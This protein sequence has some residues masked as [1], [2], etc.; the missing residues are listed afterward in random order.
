[1]KKVL[2]SL[3]SSLFVCM[4]AYSQNTF[5][6]YSCDFEDANE[7]S[8]WTLNPTANATLQGQ[9]SNKWYIGAAGDFSPTGSN[10]LFVSSD[11]GQEAVYD[12]NQTMFV[13][14][15]RE[16]PTTLPAGNY[17]LRFFW[18]GAG[19]YVSGEGV[20]VC[21]VPVSQATNSA[22]SAGGLPQWV[23]DY[24]CDS[25]NSAGTWTVANLP[26][27]HDGT[28][29][30]LVFVWYSTRGAAAPPSGCIDGLELSPDISC[31]CP[32]NVSHEMKGD[33]VVLHWYGEITN[34]TVQCYDP[35]SDTWQVGTPLLD[36]TC[37]L[38]NV[39]EG[40]QTFFIRGYCD[41]GASDIVAYTAFVFHRGKRC[42]DYMDL[43]DNN[44]Y[45]G[46]YENPFQQRQ[47]VDYGY[48][49]M[50]SR[51]TLHYMPNQYD[52]NTNYQLL[53]C[54]EGYLTSVRLGY[55]EKG[56]GNHLGHGIEY[57]YTV[58]EKENGILKIKYAVVLEDGH[59][60]DA[61]PQFWLDVKVNGKRIPNLCGYAFFRAND[62]AQNGWKTGADGWVWKD[63][64]EHAINLRDYV[65]KKLTI[66][67][68]TTDCSATVHVGY[69][70]FVLDCEGGE[71]E[72]LNCGED[73]PTT[74]LTAPSGFNYAWYAADNP[75]VVLSTE[76]V[77]QIEPL[78][79][80]IYNVNVINKNNTD[81][82]YTLTACGMPRVPKPVVTYSVDCNN[83]VTFHNYS[84]VYVQDMTTDDE[85]RRLVPSSEPVTSL[86]W[87]FGDG[88]DLLNSLDTMLT[89]QYPFSGGKFPVAVSAG[90]SH[91]ACVVSD[92][93]WLDL[94]SST[95][96]DIYHLCR[97]DYPF[98][99]KYN[100]RTYYDN[101]DEY[102]TFVTSSGC[103]SIVH[104][105]VNFHEKGPY[106]YNNQQSTDTICEGESRY[107]FDRKLTTTCVVDSVLQSVYGCDSVV[108]Y[109]L[110]VDPK[111]QSFM[112]DTISVCSEEPT[113]ELPLEITMGRY[114]G[115]V[116][117]F[118][119]E[120]GEQET[121]WHDAYQFAK[122]DRIEIPIPS[123]MPPK[124]YWAT[125]DYLTPLCPS[126]S[127]RVC[128][129]LRY[130][131]AIFYQS[132]G[133]IAIM[134]DEYNGGH[135]FK[136]YRWYRDGVLLQQTTVPYIS[137]TKDDIGHVY[138]AEVLREEDDM[139]IK[140]CEVV[141]G[142]MGIED[143]K[144]LPV[145][146]PLEAY[147]L[148]GMYMGRFASADALDALP[149]GV[150]VVRTPQGVTKLVLG[151][152]ASRLR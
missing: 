20:Y 23:K 82:W 131:S 56:K 104:L 45:I 120:Q 7:C 4:S 119:Q 74:A 35:Q 151:T 11:G 102:S 138:Y 5:A 145:T 150:Y 33:T 148:L 144:S 14:A 58:G 10:G 47:K 127:R 62:G 88:T 101:T 70:Y 128:V 68:A 51:H 53:T 24:M 112:A 84:C 142:T 34:Y 59:A 66:Q 95:K 49:N 44:C 75:D 25:L 80:T 18:Q 72:D 116:V 21:W 91:D 93:I 41:N 114:E 92:T 52:A 106:P 73:N 94:P 147:S 124:Y 48:A 87:D 83:L 28:P 111:I 103:D 16:M 97:A 134:N 137:L 9:L 79:Q 89:H 81:C 121:W 135:K 15:S 38:T 115:V 64:T 50:F 31:Q 126:P 3:L 132:N 17:K 77:F 29:H 152:P 136:G 133:I 129:E 143:V 130:S 149:T 46:T 42:I 36:K 19:K 8:L 118:D 30:K 100:G 99:F 55:G 125:L 6:V 76:Q 110:Y 39:S 140:T 109:K 117:T 71:L 123:G 86:V 141:Y 67:I 85:S 54:P 26:I 13:V 43:T 107:F 1:M 63:W 37:R 105:Q 122:D 32:Q 65:G 113:L 22:P 60:P 57:T 108:Q 90:I 61:N 96:E 2:Y 12:C 40:V 98:G 146:Y 69:V 139:W 27:T 78:D